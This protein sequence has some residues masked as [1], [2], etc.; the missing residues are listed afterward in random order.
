MNNAI[1]HHKEKANN[2]HLNNDAIKLFDQTLEFVSLIVH[3]LQGPIASMKTLTKFLM[4]GK[5]NP[6][7]DTHAALVRSC[8]NALERTESIIQD[9][10]DSADQGDFALRLNNDLCDLRDIVKNSADALAGSAYDYAVSLRLDLPKKPAIV[11]IDRYYLARVIDNLIFN[12]LKH[13]PR[14]KSVFIKLVSHNSEYVI[15]ITDQGS[16]LNEDDKDVIFDKYSQGSLR[17][18]GKY[19]G[20]GLGLYFCKL[21][22][23]AM[24]GR[25]WVETNSGEGASF[26]IAL[27]A[28]ESD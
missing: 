1:S 10:L 16:G 9:L 24:G 6:E 5:Y 25:I 22:I 21:A 18:N 26:K 13:S 23:C 28:E 2:N 4:S 17:K 19:R 27:K 3:D 15:S 11:K 8:K 14:G 20:V 12:A 7:N